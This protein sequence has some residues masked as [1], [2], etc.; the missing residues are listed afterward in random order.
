MK[1][2]SEDL[3]AGDASSDELEIIGDGDG[4]GFKDDFEEPLIDLPATEFMEIEDTAIVS[5]EEMQQ[6]T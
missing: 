4:E 3:K 1:N 5:A 6:K 2:I